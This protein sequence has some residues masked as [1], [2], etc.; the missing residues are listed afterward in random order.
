MANAL[1][2]RHLTS[3]KARTARKHMRVPSVKKVTLEA[4]AGSKLKRVAS[5]LLAPQALSR[6]QII[7][8]LM[9]ASEK[10][11]EAGADSEEARTI[12][13]NK[14]QL[15]ALKSNPNANT[16]LTK[17]QLK[18]L[19]NRVRAT[20]LLNASSNQSDMQL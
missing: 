6:V 13:V 9:A 20:A 5:S 8:D 10:V 3:F 7:P 17:K 16:S 18:K 11:L 12:I 19:K 2:T 4:R 15:Q 1:N 14:H